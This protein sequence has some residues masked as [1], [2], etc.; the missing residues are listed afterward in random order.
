VGGGLLAPTLQQQ[1]RIERAAEAGKA[2]AG[3]AASPPPPPWETPDER[4]ARE[5]EAAERGD[6]GLPPGADVAE[7]EAD[8]SARDP[9]ALLEALSLLAGARHHSPP[10]RRMLLPLLRFAGPRLLSTDGGT[11]LSPSSA[12]ESLL[13]PPEPLSSRELVDLAHAMARIGPSAA[14]TR[15]F[16]A[17]L[18][19]ALRARGFWAEGEGEER[20]DGDDDDNT[21]ARLSWALPQLAAW[22]D[23]EDDA[24]TGPSPTPDERALWHLLIGR[25]LADEETL[26]WLEREQR[27]RRRR[28]A[29]ASGGA[30]AAEPLPQGC[31]VSAQL[32]ACANLVRRRGPG[33]TP[34]RDLA[35]MLA[36]PVSLAQQLEVAA[37]EQAPAPAAGGENDGDDNTNNNPSAF[38]SAAAEAVRAAA[39]PLAHAA[40]DS[41]KP[42]SS[43]SPLPLTVPFEAAALLGALA[44]LGARPSSTW[45]RAAATA[46]LDED[47]M[48]PL[49]ELG[50]L[51]DVS[52]ALLAFVSRLEQGQE[53]SIPPEERQAWARLLQRAILAAGAAAAAQAAEAGDR[54]ADLAA[55]R[56]QRAA[57]EAAEALEALV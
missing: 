6:F 11:P 40:L 24:S 36:L 55:S 34:A 15:R 38:Y 37:A 52:R 10:N 53:D 17:Q 29:G 7:V 35:N 1:T 19:L 18:L 20:D 22:A 56:V 45:V 23:D 42:A 47:F 3:A 51:A 2:T 8:E 44:A 21:L 14:P 41:L 32:T 46:A 27:R 33:N 28:E 13:R 5:R 50:E 25:T 39:L 9:R 26:P 57:R 31:V 54:R 43:L 4:A 48:L 49:Y 16:L 30:N 12:A